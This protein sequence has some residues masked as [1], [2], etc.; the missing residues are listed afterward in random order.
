MRLLDKGG[1]DPRGI[2]HPPGVL[3][4]AGRLSLRAAASASAEPAIHDYFSRAKLLP[5][6]HASPGL[7]VCGSCRPSLFSWP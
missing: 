6:R 1:K 2:F 5:P 7:N 3:C 4:S